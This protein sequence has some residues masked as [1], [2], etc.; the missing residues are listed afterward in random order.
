MTMRNRLFSCIIIFTLLL[1]GCGPSDTADDNQI[2]ATGFIEG[3]IYT[4]ASE[5]GGSVTEVLVEQGEQISAGQTLLKLDT[6]A[7]EHTRDQA[8][9][10]VDAAQAA[11]EALE[12]LPRAEAVA[13]GEAALDA[14]EAKLVEAQSVLALLEAAYDPLPFDPPE[15]ELHAAE[16][17]VEIAE[18]GVDLAQAQLDQIN[19]GPLEGEFEMAEAA[20]AGAQANLALAE[21]QIERMTLTSPVDGVVNQVLVKPGEVASPGGPLLQVVDPDYLTLT[22]FIPAVQVPNIKIGDEATISVDAYSDEV[23][24]GKVT[25]IADRAQFTPSNVQTREERVKLVFAVEI[26][27]DYNGGRL[28]AGMPADA[29]FGP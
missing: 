7:L 2:E 29:V 24:S 22:L 16:A 11:L 17:A 12:S 10:G 19:A 5:L 15:A 20:L 1:T 26:L 3:R 14:A 8:L 18:A 23:F 25:A 6:T 27:L 9:A 28:K 21:L 4:V 13:A